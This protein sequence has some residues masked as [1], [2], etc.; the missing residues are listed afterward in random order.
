MTLSMP[1]RSFRVVRLTV[2]VIT[3]AYKD[4]LSLRHATSVDDFI[5]YSKSP[6]PSMY[7]QN[8]EH[9]IIVFQETCLAHYDECGR[10]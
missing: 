8:S 3:I 1:T 5:R 9:S 2:K 7:R 10:V 4:I 6:P